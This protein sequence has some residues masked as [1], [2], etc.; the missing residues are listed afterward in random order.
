MPSMRP[1]QRLPLVVLTCVALASCASG[2]A[3]AGSSGTGSASCAAAVVYQGHT[4]LGHGGVKRD[5]ATTGRLVEG[6]VPS[7]DDS[8]GQEPV[9]PDERVPVAELADVPLETAFLWNGGV[10]LRNGRRLP[11]ATETWFREQRCTSAGEFD[12]TA[13]WLGAAGPVKPRFDGDLRPPYRLEV[14]VTEGPQKYVGTTIRVHADAATD[15]ALGTRD[16]RTSLWWA[17]RSSLASA[18]STAASGRTPC[19]S[20]GARELADRPRNGDIR[21]ASQG[22]EGT[23]DRRVRTAGARVPARR[24]IAPMPRHA[25]L[26]ADQAGSRP[27]PA[28]TASSADAPAGTGRA[29][30]NASPRASSEPGP[31]IIATNSRDGASVASSRTSC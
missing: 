17:D 22:R 6:V 19:E 9:E 3:G 16:V 30:P 21:G 26:P 11:A 5:P 7:C 28:M 23:S 13:D 20:H 15:P 8:G 29:G 31:D 27:L 25:A 10:Y 18:A 12:L 4:Y 1:P 2:D 24:I 14:H